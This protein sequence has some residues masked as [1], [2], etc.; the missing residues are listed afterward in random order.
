MQ[1]LSPGSG[2]EIIDLAPTSRLQSP[3]AVMVEGSG[4]SRSV[5]IARG[6][7]VKVISHPPPPRIS[8]ARECTTKTLQGAPTFGQRAHRAHCASLMHPE[9]LPSRLTP[10]QPSRQARQTLVLAA[11]HGGLI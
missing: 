3:P 1:Q 5:V 7:V 4:R 8:H 10:R 6:G 11:L 9:R 2:R